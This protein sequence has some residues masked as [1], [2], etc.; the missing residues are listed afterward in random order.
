MPVK[1][2]VIVTVVL[3]LAVPA[4]AAGQQ[5]NVAVT[6]EDYA[7]AEKW[8]FTEDGSPPKYVANLLPIPYW[9]GNTDEF[10]Y[11]RETKDGFEFVI[12]SASTGEKRTAFDQDAIA[13]ALRRAG[14]EDADPDSLPFDSFVFEDSRNT[15]AFEIDGRTYRCQLTARLECIGDPVPEREPGLLVSPNGKLAIYTEDA[16]LHLLEL[17][18]GNRTALTKD[19][20]PN[21][22]YGIYYGNW[23]ASFIAREKSGQRQ[24][25]MEAK[26]SPDSRK[27]LVTRLDD[28]HVKAYPFIET[29][30]DDDTHRPK[31]YLPRIPLTGERPA[32]LEWYVVDIKSGALVRLDL[33][34]EKLF[35]LHQDMT[36]LRKVWWSADGSALYALAW[37]HN[38]EAAY[39]LDINLKTG[40]TRIAVEEHAEPRMDTNSTT[41]NPPNVE[42]IRGGE[43]VLWFSQRDGWGHLYLYD[44]KTGVLK[45]RVTAGDWLVRDIVSIDERKRFVYFTGG[46]REKGNPYYRYLYRARLDGTEIL[47]LSPEHGDH[48]ITSPYNDVLAFDGAI[49]YEVVSPSGNYIA[50]SYS[51]PAQPTRS[52][53]RRIGDVQDFFEFERADASELYRNGWRDPEEFVVKAADGTTDLYGLLFRPA[54]FDPKRSYPIINSQYASPL[55]AVVPRNFNQATRPIPGRTSQMS[56]SELGFAVVVID[57]RGTTYRS[58][59]FAHYSWLNLNTIGMEDHIAAIRQLADRYPW[60]DI[61]RVGIHGSS[62][63]GYT[64]FRAMFEFPEFYKVGISNVGVGSFHNMYPDYHWEAFHGDAVYANGT[65][66]YDDP[67]ETP[68]NYR[69]NDSLVQ[70]ENLEGQLLIMLGELDEN[71]FPATTLQLVDRLI[72][73]DKDFEMLYVPGQNHSFRGGHFE[74]RMWNFFVHHLHGQP[75]PKYRMHRR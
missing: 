30:P 38:L 41:Y 59:E 62:Y 56:L 64:A 45:N 69:N 53:V 49:G 23:K 8:A 46:G 13:V 70:A 21:N 26:W 25:P 72:E 54:D 33:P 51:R 22:G 14:I 34:Y 68:V 66:Y 52:V 50:Y 5:A 18:S 73:L 16:N 60:M 44:L 20:E 32:L 35:H 43:E 37:G 75:P 36:A 63:G 28:R 11:R 55:T 2:L 40:Q 19:G 3:T 47:L 7:R 61:N 12:V 57:A 24:V 15:I 29:A 1:F 10:W 17:D 71:V 39:L 31:L 4:A 58:R 27:V 65:P 67:A 6:A 9:I 48:L 74:R 42:V